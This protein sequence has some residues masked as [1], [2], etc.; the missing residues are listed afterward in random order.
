[1]S[2]SCTWYDRQKLVPLAAEYGIVITSAAKDGRQTPFDPLEQLTLLKRGF[3]PVSGSP[4][5]ALAPLEL[6]SIVRP[7]IF[8]VTEDLGSPPAVR[9][10]NVL[11]NAQRE[12][13]AHGR[14]AFYDFQDRIPE[15]YR[16]GSYDLRVRRLN[17]DELYAEMML[18]QLTTWEGGGQGAPAE[19]VPNPLFQG[20][21]VCSGVAPAREVAPSDP[22]GPTSEFIFGDGI[23]AHT[24]APAP[25]PLRVGA[26]EGN[27]KDWLTRPVIVY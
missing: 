26:I 1:M 27:D 11:E 25:P 2:P 13:V 16:D 4:G 3:I 6:A 8:R 10:A 20:V 15:S 18:G 12:M 24:I 17:Y 5:L 22:G 14:T 7:L 9:D 21:L 23:V 19:G